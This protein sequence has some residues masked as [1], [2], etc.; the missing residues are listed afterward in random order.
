MSLTFM[1][2]YKMFFGQTS[3]LPPRM[4]QKLTKHESFVSKTTNS[5]PKIMLSQ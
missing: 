1:N 5:L 3:T 2:Q 4:L